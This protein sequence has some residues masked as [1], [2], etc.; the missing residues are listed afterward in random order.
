MQKKLQASVL[1]YTLFL[2]M[3]SLVFAVV[4]FNIAG[5]VINNNEYQNITR[6]LTSDIIYK[7]DLAVKYL[8]KLNSNGG[9]FFD[10]ISCPT[11][12]TLS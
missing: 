5:V 9:G 11:A 7:G 10:N 8:N 1:V 2:I 3:I 4:V 12:V 6:K